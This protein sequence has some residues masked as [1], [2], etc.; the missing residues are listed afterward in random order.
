[1]KVDGGSMH[2]SSCF[3]M[4][5]NCRCKR[6]EDLPDA[7][8]EHQLGKGSKSLLLLQLTREN[9]L[10]YKN[11][12]YR[13]DKNDIRKYERIFLSGKDRVTRSKGKWKCG[14]LAIIKGMLV[15]KGL[16]SDNT[17]CQT[18][19]AYLMILLISSSMIRLSCASCGSQP[20][21]RGECQGDLFTSLDRLHNFRQQ[22]QL[23]TRLLKTAA[24]IATFSTIKTIKSK[25]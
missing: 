13:F 16:G 4:E 9:V 24:A 23:I 6:T 7:D 21:S 5:Q 20:I 3:L 25:Q 8:E 14:N 2:S 10:L 1:M 18:A 22:Q 11:N 15:I 12:L 17:G 19:F